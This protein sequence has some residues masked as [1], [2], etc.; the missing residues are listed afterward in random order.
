MSNTTHGDSTKK[1]K[2][3]QNETK[4]EGVTTDTLRKLKIYGIEAQTK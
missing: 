1:W 3:L 2:K 4:V